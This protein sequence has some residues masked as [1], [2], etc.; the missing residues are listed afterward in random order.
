MRPGQ[1]IDGTWRWVTGV[2][3]QG[4]DMVIQPRTNDDVIEG[5]SDVCL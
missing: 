3:Q 4:A 2:V 5:G 1:P